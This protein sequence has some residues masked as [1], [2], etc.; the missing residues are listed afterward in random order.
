MVWAKVRV[1]VGAGTDTL[2]NRGIGQ[3]E[4]KGIEPT[5]RG[6]DLKHRVV[7]ETE[8][9]AARGNARSDAIRSG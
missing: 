2:K 3:L 5:E 7:C 4:I 6:D 9:L 8:Q 1:N